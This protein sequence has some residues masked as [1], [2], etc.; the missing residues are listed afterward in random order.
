VLNIGLLAAG[1]AV[2]ISLGW[3]AAAYA[4]AR[5]DLLDAQARGSATVEALAQVGIATQEAHADES[6][7]LIDNA[8]DNGG[9]ELYESDYRTKKT[10]LGPGPGTLLTAALTAAHGTPAAPAVAAT[11][12]DAGSWFAAHSAV[13]SL[14]DNAK[15]GT[16]VDSVLGTASG[17]TGAAYDR[18]LAAIATATSQDQTVFDSTAGSAS[19]A[20]TG[21]EP[22]LIV[23]SLIMAAG[24]A[25]GISRRLA[26]YR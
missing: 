18:L 26:E 23:A 22:G 15:H 14:D 11:V 6:L 12:R 3:T 10:A 20:Y 24:C 25:W 17:T 21:L 7:T 8:G 1:A 2:V 9:T 16:A 5:G 19:G 4:V 13:R